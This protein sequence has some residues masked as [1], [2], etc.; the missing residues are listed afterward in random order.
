MNIIQN[1]TI[2]QVIGAP[3]ILETAERQVER[4]TFEGQEHAVEYG[5]VMVVFMISFLLTR[6]AA[7]LEK[8]LA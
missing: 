4:L 7:Y 3:E 1:T 5:A 8:R 2:V 6:L